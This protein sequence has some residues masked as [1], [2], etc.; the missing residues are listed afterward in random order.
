MS[1]YTTRTFSRYSLPSACLLSL[2]SP[3]VSVGLS[4]GLVGSCFIPRA[5]SVPELDCLTCMYVYSHLV[6]VIIFF[7]YT[8]S[9]LFVTSVYLHPSVRGSKSRVCSGTLARA[10]RRLLR[11]SL[12]RCRLKQLDCRSSSQKETPSSDGSTRK[13]WVP[14]PIHIFSTYVLMNQFYGA[15]YKVQNVVVCSESIMPVGIL[16]MI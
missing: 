6:S 1:A 8:F 5:H 3:A 4:V 13:W 2:K 12:S 16:D 14:R 11:L 7:F 10:G 15:S 9:M